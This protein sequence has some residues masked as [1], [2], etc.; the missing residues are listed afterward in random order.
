MRT[1]NGPSPSGSVTGVSSSSRMREPSG[2]MA[3]PRAERDRTAVDE[4]AHPDADA[5]EADDLA[6]VLGGRERAVLQVV[7]VQRRDPQ[8]VDEVG[9]WCVDHGE[10]PVDGSV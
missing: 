10:P 9:A 1:A 4:Q 5:A 3:S 7:E 8:A 2:A 6:Q